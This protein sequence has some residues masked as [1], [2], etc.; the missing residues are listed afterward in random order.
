MWI[1]NEID[2]IVDY[3][4]RMILD[5]AEVEV[6]WVEVEDLEDLV[7]DQEDSHHHHHH[8]VEVEDVDLT[9]IMIVIRSSVGVMD[10]MIV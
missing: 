8:M 9:M 5:L 7:E 1:W 6:E 2:A 10:P 4:H 3:H